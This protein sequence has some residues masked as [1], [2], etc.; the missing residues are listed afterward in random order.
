MPPTI[1]K[2]RPSLWNDDTPQAIAYKKAYFVLRD[3]GEQCSDEDFVDS[4]DFSDLAAVTN[5]LDLLQSYASERKHRPVFHSFEQALHLQDDQDRVNKVHNA[6][7]AI[8]RSLDET[9]EKRSH[10]LAG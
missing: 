9:Y 4:L 6:L 7:K 5:A 1:F 8:W 10:V 3:I 2:L